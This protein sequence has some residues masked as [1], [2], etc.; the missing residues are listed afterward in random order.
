MSSSLPAIREKVGGILLL[1]LIEKAGTVS[2]E[3]LEEIIP[4]EE[5]SSS[6]FFFLNVA[7]SFSH[8]CSDVWVISL[9]KVEIL[10]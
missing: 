5:P 9:W 3:V 8:F 7:Y 6:D 1:L 4:E 10:K 2:L